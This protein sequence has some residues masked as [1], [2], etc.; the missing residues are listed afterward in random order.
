MAKRN[1]AVLILSLV[2]FTGCAELMKTIQTVSAVKQLTEGDITGGLKEALTIGAR[3]AASRLASQ[4]GYWGDP[5]VRIPLPD[6]AKV[7]IDNIGRI[8]GGQQLIDNVILS[9]NRAAED[10]AREVAPIIAGSV[11]RMTISDGYNILHGADNAATEYLRRT[12]WNELYSLYRPKIS[13]STGKE[14]IAGISAQES[15]NTLT[16]KWNSVAN[17]VAGRLAGFNTVTTDLDDFLTNKAL[18]GVFL[19]LAGEE[20][21]I[22]KEVSARVTPLLREVFG[23]LDQ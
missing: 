6:E 10:A 21:K 18:E 2:L 12:T 13:T 5:S 9:I 4:D 14:I 16:Q 8:P 19:K 1:I 23:T 3:N 17:S 22:R 20:L 7:I 11:T 15:W